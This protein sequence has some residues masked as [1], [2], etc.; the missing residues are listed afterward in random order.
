MEEGPQN[1]GQFSKFSLAIILSWALI[2][3]LSSN[4]LPNCLTILLPPAVK[5]W[6]SE[7]YGLGNYGPMDLPLLP[8]NLASPWVLMWQISELTDPFSFSTSGTLGFYYK[9]ISSPNMKIPLGQLLPTPGYLC[10]TVG[11]MGC[12]GLLLCHAQWATSV[13]KTCTIEKGS[14]E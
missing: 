12:S 11:Y 8:I 2:G 1:L 14:T 4:W 6:V 13:W 7:I 3:L 5:I 10:F 9:V